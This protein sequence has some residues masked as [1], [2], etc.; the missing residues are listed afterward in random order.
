MNKMVRLRS[1]T[2]ETKRLVIYMMTARDLYNYSQ[3]WEKLN[4]E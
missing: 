1:K 4:V 3:G 2:L